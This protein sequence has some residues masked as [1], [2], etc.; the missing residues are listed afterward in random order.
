MSR[1]RVAVSI[2]DRP[3]RSRLFRLIAPLASCPCLSRRSTFWPASRKA[4][5]A[6]IGDGRSREWTA[7]ASVLGRADDRP[8]QGLLIFARASRRSLPRYRSDVRGG[9]RPPRPERGHGAPCGTQGSDFP[10]PCRHGPGNTPGGLRIHPVAAP[11]NRPSGPP[12]WERRLPLLWSARPAGNMFIPTLFD[13]TAE[14]K[15]P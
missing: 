13:M 15:Q 7:L 14:L 12:R 4:W 10:P 3:Q 1:A 11:K 5:W 8:E 9:I 6:H 2:A